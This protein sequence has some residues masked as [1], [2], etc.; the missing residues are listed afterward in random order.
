MEENANHEVAAVV[1]G[2]GEW[3]EALGP[4]A[5]LAVKKEWM[6]RERN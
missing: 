3:R 5:I 2:G 4:D 1:V 6:E